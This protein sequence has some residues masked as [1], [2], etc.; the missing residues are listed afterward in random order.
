M[1]RLWRLCRKSWGAG[2]APL[3]E[4]RWAFFFFFFSGPVVSSRPNQAS[5]VP[6]PPATKVVPVRA[7]PITVTPRH[8]RVL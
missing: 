8:Q 1:L 6:V 4:C 3:V 5:V 2:V 7:P